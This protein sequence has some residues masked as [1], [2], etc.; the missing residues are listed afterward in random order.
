M[1]MIQL[2]T[3]AGVENIVAPLQDVE[4][5]SVSTTSQDGGSHT[6]SYG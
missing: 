2:Y 1:S 3:N 5:A 4:A 6:Q